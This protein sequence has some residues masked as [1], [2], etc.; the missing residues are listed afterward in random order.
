MRASLER[1]LR[2][3]ED[4]LSILP[5]CPDGLSHFYDLVAAAEPLGGLLPLMVR[6]ER[7]EITDADDLLLSSAAGGQGTLQGLARFWPAEA[8][9]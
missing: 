4:R 5:V 7:G 9:V 2:A 3:L 6:V 8:A 1:R